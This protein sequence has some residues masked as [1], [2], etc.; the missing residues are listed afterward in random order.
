[1]YL[2]VHGTDRW[3]ESTLCLR[4]IDEERKSNAIAETE[5][6]SRANRK[7]SISH[8]D[9]SNILGIYPDYEQVVSSSAK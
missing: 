8:I 2:E 6:Q 3:M 1:M 9:S 7:R 5:R 4:L